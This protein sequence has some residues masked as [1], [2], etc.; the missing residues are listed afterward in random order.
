MRKPLALGLIIL[1]F[2]LGIQPVQ[3]GTFY[4]HEHPSYWWYVVDDPAFS[5]IIPS[6]ADNYI[7]R[8][9]FGMEHLL[10]TFQKGTITM[11]VIYQPGTDIE[12]VR[13]SLDV[14]YKPVVKNLTILSNEEITTSNNLKAHFYAYQGTGANGKQ[15][16]LRSVFFQKGRHVVYLTLFLEAD[17]YQGD[18][19]EYWIRAVNGF[20]WN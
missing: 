9:I 6:G 11:E 2:F 3:A 12:S 1:F 8:S 10:M 19:R 13:N 14:R 20:E 17:Q 5:A 16:M 7:E 18:L 4:L 15:V